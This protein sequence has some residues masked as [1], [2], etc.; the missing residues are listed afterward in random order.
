MIN[1]RQE[2]PVARVRQL[3]AG[4]GADVVYDS[5]AGPEFAQ[6]FEMCRAGGTV[7]LFG[8]VLLPYVR[9]RNPEA[10]ARLQE[11]LV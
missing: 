2:D 8:Q 6:S 3:S 5:V 10:R 11:E 9:Q 1:Y 4:A 7:V